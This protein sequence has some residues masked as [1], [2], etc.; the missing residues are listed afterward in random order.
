MRDRHAR[1][2]AANRRPISSFRCAGSRRPTGGKPPTEPPASAELTDG[3][4]HSRS[5]DSR[6]A[7]NN[8]NA[9]ARPIQRR[10]AA[11]RSTLPTTQLAAVRFQPLDGA[12]AT[13]WDEIRDLKLAN[14][15]LVVLKT[16]GK[17]LDYVEGVMGDVS[18]DKVEFKLDGEANRVD[19]AKSPA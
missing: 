3:Y 6:V 7:G 16:D 19:R 2:R 11:N 8:G 4:A 12:L 10:R 5:S 1:R 17:S 14:D 9:H 15:V 13:Q 18:D